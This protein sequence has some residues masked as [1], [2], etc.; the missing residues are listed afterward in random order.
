MVKKISFYVKCQ[1]VLHC[2]MFL[3][4]STFN[5]K[6]CDSIEPQTWPIL[7]SPWDHLPTLDSRL[8]TLLHM[9]GSIVK[10]GEGQ[11]VCLWN[12]GTE[13]KHGPVFLLPQSS[14]YRELVNPIYW[15]SSN[16]Q[17]GDPREAAKPGPRPSNFLDQ[18]KGWSGLMVPGWLFLL[19]WSGV[20]QPQV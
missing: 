17:S 2:P 12:T 3:F 6:F 4:D 9:E 11:H 5:V 1:Q 7:M 20:H 13:M 19:K 8:G 16:L 10:A 14:D 15:Q 18:T